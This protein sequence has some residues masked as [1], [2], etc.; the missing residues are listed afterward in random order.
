MPTTDD[1]GIVIRHR[2]PTSI[3]PEGWSILAEPSIATN[4]QLKEAESQV[5]LPAFGKA[6]SK[7]HTPNTRR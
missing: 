6:L 4:T 3:L 2:V 5:A 7:R 1:D